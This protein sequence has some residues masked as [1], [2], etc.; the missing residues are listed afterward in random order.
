MI[1]QPYFLCYYYHKAD[2]VLAEKKSVGFLGASKAQTRCL[3][4]ENKT[5]IFTAS[6]NYIF[7]V[8]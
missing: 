5:L 4:C 1:A 3:Q 8:A 2:S 6:N 7:V